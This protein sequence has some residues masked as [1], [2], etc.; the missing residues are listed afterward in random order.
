VECGSRGLVGEFF[1]VMRELGVEGEGFGRGQT[2]F[3][4]GDGN[5]WQG[6]ID[7]FVQVPVFLLDAVG[8]VGVGEGDGHA[9]GAGGGAFADVVVEELFAPFEFISISNK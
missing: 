5:G 7:A 4:L 9:E 3:V 1:G 2:L 6:D 8:V